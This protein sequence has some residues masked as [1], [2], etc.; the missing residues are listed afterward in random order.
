MLGLQGCNE[1]NK[2]YLKPLLNINVLIFMH[3]IARETVS[4][5]RPIKIKLNSH[6]FNWPELKSVKAV[7]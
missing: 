7:G 3:R 4:T 2:Q 1:E 5:K 6:A